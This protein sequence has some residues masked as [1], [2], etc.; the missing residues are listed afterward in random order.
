MK[1]VTKDRNW[2][3]VYT[4]ENYTLPIDC[5]DFETDYLIDISE[6][7]Y[8]NEVY[9]SYVELKINDKISSYYNNILLSWTALQSPI[10]IRTRQMKANTFFLVTSNS[11]WYDEWRE[12]SYN[13]NF[14]LNDSGFLI[15][16]GDDWY[17][18]LEILDRLCEQIF[19]M[20]FSLHVN[21]KLRMCMSIWL[22]W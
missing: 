18:D 21:W 9:P 10:S 11:T 19:P 14:G 22:F 4:G 13:S 2:T 6:I 17:S 1:D 5:D 16:Y 7:Y 3:E 12:S 8:W 20:K 15:I